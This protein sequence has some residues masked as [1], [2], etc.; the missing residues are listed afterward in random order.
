MRGVLPRTLRWKGFPAPVV[1]TTG[2]GAEQ[3]TAVVRPECLQMQGDM[4]PLCLQC[5]SKGSIVVCDV[6]AWMLMGDGGVTVYVVPRRGAIFG[7]V[8]VLLDISVI[9]W[10]LRATSVD[11]TIRAG[12]SKERVKWKILKIKSKF[13]DTEDTSREHKIQISHGT[14]AARKN[15]L[16]SSPNHNGT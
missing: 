3:E 8:N 9:C 13:R 4:S 15:S 14:N 16:V 2:T 10:F 11:R 12:A 5:P 7:K 1:R 6:A